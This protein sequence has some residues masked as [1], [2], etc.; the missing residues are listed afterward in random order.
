VIEVPESIGRPEFSFDL[1]SCDDSSWARKQHLQNLKWL[2]LKPDSNPVF[3]EFARPQIDLEDAKNDPPGRLI[4]CQHR[5]I[6]WTGDEFIISALAVPQV[7]L[8]RFA[9]TPLLIMSYPGIRVS[10]N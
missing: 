1:F 6:T 10:S 2:C 5:F 8:G 4:H 7:T 3:S 9:I